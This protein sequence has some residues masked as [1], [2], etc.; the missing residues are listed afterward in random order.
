VYE[1][2]TKNHPI[3][4]DFTSTSKEHRE[5]ENPQAK[6]D[7][8]NLENTFD[9]SQLNEQQTKYLLGLQSIYN[10]LNN[11]SLNLFKEE[12]VSSAPDDD[13]TEDNQIF[14][15]YFTERADKPKASVDALLSLPKPS[16][17]NNWN[18][19]VVDERSPPTV[20]EEPTDKPEFFGTLSHAEADA[21]YASSV[22]DNSFKG[23]IDNVECP[24]SP[25]ETHRQLEASINDIMT[26]IK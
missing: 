9:A 12:P 26:L 22:I 23:I 20:T 15:Y 3:Q 4:R 7:L 19:F 8:E 6:S 16:Y 14:S 5:K 17:L 10:E 21:Q 11:T 18:H 1:V 13:L 24:L 2:S 25:L